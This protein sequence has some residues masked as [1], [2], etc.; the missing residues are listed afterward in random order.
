MELFSN[1]FIGKIRDKYYTFF[2][3]PVLGGVAWSQGS[4]AFHT[5][6]DAHQFLIDKCKEASTPTAK[7]TC[8]EI[9]AQ[10]MGIREEVLED[11]AS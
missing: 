9:A 11:A 7:I 5:L 4:D 2:E 3:M 1:Y 6:E 10:Y 8:V